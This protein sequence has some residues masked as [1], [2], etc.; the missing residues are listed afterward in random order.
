MRVTE[1]YPRLCASELAHRIRKTST[2]TSLRFQQT[3]IIELHL[4]ALGMEIWQRSGN[5]S[6][7]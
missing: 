4:E 7:G 3:S 6:M 5:L 2:L 1:M